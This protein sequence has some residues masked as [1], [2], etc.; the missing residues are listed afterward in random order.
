MRPRISI[1]VLALFHR[2]MAG[3][4]VVYLGRDHPERNHSFLTFSRFNMNKSRLLAAQLISI[5]NLTEVREM[6]RD[7]SLLAL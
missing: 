4:E 3:M 5:I 7:V 6:L 2:C 1:H